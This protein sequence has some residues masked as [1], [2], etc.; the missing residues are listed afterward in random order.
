MIKGHKATYYVMKP[1][2]TTCPYTILQ[3]KVTMWVNEL[4]SG[5]LRSPSIFLVYSMLEAIWGIKGLLAFYYFFIFCQSSPSP[6][7]WERQF[8][9]T[10]TVK[11]SPSV[12]APLQLSGCPKEHRPPF[13]VKGASSLAV[14]RPL[15]K[16]AWTLKTPRE[17]ETDQAGMSAGCPI[18]Q[19][20]GW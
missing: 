8:S 5:N 7:P 10:N 14:L 19:S 4:L 20:V 16:G 9:Y 18:C 3:V 1:S 11:P 15:D 17:H 2:I 6:L 12:L 13:S